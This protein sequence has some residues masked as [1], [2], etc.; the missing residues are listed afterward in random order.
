MDEIQAALI[1]R[2]FVIRGFD[3]PGFQIVYKIC[4]LRISLV[5]RGFLK[6]LA[7]KGIKLLEQRS[8][9][10]RGFGISAICAGRT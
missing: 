8:L 1:S 7:Q 9:V 2:G 6:F 4:Y 3:Y 10:I 5:I